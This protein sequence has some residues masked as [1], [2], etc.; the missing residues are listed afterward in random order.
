MDVNPPRFEGIPHGG[1]RVRVGD[2]E[3]GTAIDC[4][5][6]ADWPAG[7]SNFVLPQIAYHVR[8]GRLYVPPAMYPME[9]PTVKLRDV[10]DIGPSHLQIKGGSVGHSGPFNVVEWRPGCLYPTLWNNHND[11]QRQM[12]VSPD[13]ALEPRR[14]GDGDAAGRILDTASH[15]HMS[16]DTDTT[17][18]HLM[19]PYTARPVVGGTAWPSIIASE[20]LQKGL[21]VWCNCTLGI[22]ARWAMSNHEQIRRSRSSCTAIRDLPVLEPA[23]LQRLAI[24]YD[25]FAERRVGRIMHLWRDEVRIDMDGVV[26]DILG[27]DADLDYIRKHLCAEPTMNGDRLPADLREALKW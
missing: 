21:A 25:E 22:L 4:P 3:V 18:Q 14:D 6:D 16:I 8:H 11:T 9:M 7:V 1:G 10:A 17:S 24:V 12:A 26:L 13:H 15:L 23:A 20:D 5:L 27:L 19:A 2:D